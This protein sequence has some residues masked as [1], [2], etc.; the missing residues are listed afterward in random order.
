MFKKF[1]ILSAIFIVSSCLDLQAQVR[2]VKSAKDRNPTLMFRDIAGNPELSKLIASDLRYCG[3]FDLVD[4]GAEYVVTG[5]ASGSQLQTNI[6]NAN[7]SPVFSLN[8]QVNPR[9]LRT[10]AHKTVDAILKKMFNIAGICSSKIAFAAQTQVGKKEIFTCD[11][12]GQNVTQLTFNNSLSV[13]PDWIPG[14]NAIVFTLYSKMF[15]DIV[16]LDVNSKRCRR[17]AQFPGLNSGAAVSPNSSKLALILSRDKQVE[18]YVKSFGGT[19][20]RRL[21]SGIGVEASPCWSPSGDKLCFVS[22]MG[23]RPGLYI[24]SPGGGAPVKL[25]TLGSEAVSPSWSSDNKIAYSAKTGNYTIAILDL[26]GREAARTVVNAA[27]NWESPSWAPD[28]RHLVC[29]R[30]SGGSSA[31]FIVDTWTGRTRPLIGGKLNTV[32]PSWSGIR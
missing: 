15:T 27:G 11:F 28:A 2:V 19:D 26:N 8:T 23:G 21:T 32:L 14:R 30:T 24:I 25:S 17:I 31:L 3:W 18:L 20:L 29:A 1:L 22:D 9:D 5:S 13:E 6:S 16:E 10:T 4:S 7:G 12:D